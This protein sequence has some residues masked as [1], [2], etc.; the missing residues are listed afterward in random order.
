MANRNPLAGAVFDSLLAEFET[1]F[2]TRWESLLDDDAQKRKL[3]LWLGDGL[4][5][6]G[7]S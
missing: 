1:L 2:W 7:L 5:M 3:I 6:H 4:Y